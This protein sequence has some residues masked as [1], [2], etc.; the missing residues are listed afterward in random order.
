MFSH[1]AEQARLVISQC[2]EWGLCRHHKTALGRAMTCYQVADGPTTRR[3]G[4]PSTSI[5]YD[6]SQDLDP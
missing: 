2:F 5:R 6:N 4:E 1:P 3:H